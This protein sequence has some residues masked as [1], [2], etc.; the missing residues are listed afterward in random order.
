M[1]LNQV[2]WVLNQTIKMTVMLM[3]QWMYP[4]GVIRFNNW[5]RLT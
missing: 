4:S 2:S 3:E 1:E 5:E